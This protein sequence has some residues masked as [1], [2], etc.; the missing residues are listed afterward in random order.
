MTELDYSVLGVVWREAP[1]TSYAVR[2]FFAESPTRSWSSSAGSIYP[3]IKRLV[4]E[5]LVLASE[6]RGGRGTRLLSA[7]GQGVAALRQW[8]LE[9]A[10][11]IGTATPDPIR[12]RTFYLAVLEQEGRKAFLSAAIRST[13]AALET[14]TSLAEALETVADQ[15]S[16]YLGALGAVFELRARREW[17]DLVKRELG[18]S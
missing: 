11:D 1:I 14:A 10:P 17:L 3:A 6:P 2:R 12:T 7:T 13:E 5:G 15:R 16:R 8:L 4:G 9:V 18:G